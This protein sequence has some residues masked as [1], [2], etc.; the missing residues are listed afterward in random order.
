MKG[1]LVISHGSR[2]SQTKSELEHLVGQLR[3]SSSI[4][5]ITYAFL[6]IESPSIPEG[7]ASCYQAGAR[8]LLIVL[9]FLNSGRHVDEDIP[10]IVCDSQAGY[11]DM[12]ITLSPPVGQH[13]G[14]IDLFLDLMGELKDRPQNR[15]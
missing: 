14:M 3:R 4:P 6:E 10:R 12:K 7:I 1:V 11:P 13:P 2:S 15:L 5:I 8:S 9:N